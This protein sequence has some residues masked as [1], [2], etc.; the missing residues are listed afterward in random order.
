MKYILALVILVSTKIYAQTQDREFEGVITYKTTLVPKNKGIDVERFYNVFGKETLYYFKRGK[1]KWAPLNSE[2]EY[3][4]FNPAAEPVVIDKLQQ[5]DT[6]YYK[7]QRTTSDSITSV[8]SVGNM[9]ILNI[10]CSSAVFA[11]SYLPEDGPKIYRTIYYPTDSLQYAKAYYDNCLSNGQGFIARYA[12]SI[13]L[14]MELDSPGFP[15]V[16]IY[17]ATSLQWKELPESVFL[18]DEKLPVKK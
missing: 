16:V 18:V 2:L 1:Y 17:E 9:T 4:I 13:A 10:P 6:L 11:L 8:R 3:E 7:D 14:R 15:F 12:K 5:N